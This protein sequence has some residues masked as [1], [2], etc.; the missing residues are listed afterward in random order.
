MNYCD[1]KLKPNSWGIYIFLKYQL[2]STTDIEI[3]IYTHIHNKYLYNIVMYV[4]TFSSDVFQNWKQLDERINTLFSFGIHLSLIVV[5]FTSNCVRITVLFWKCV[6]F[7]PGNFSIRVAEMTIGSSVG[8]TH[9][10]TQFVQ[11][12]DDFLRA[13]FLIGISAATL[14]PQWPWTY[15]AASFTV[16]RGCCLHLFTWDPRRHNEISMT[17]CLCVYTHLTLRT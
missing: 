8:G 5:H 9:R 13:T 3:Y 10:K 12:L 15:S 16:L 1:T 7:I 4:E 6:F 11:S 17:V 2:G 14:S